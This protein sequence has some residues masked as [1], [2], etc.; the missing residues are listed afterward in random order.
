LQG[1]GENRRLSVLGNV[2]ACV[3]AGVVESTCYAPFEH[4]KTQLQTQYGRAGMRRPP[5]SWRRE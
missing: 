3:S 2:A 5:L 4:I 1:E